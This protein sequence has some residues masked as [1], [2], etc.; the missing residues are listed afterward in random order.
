MNRKIIVHS[1]VL[2]FFL[3]GVSVVKGWLHLSYWPLWLGAAAGFFLPDVDHLVYV[4]FLGNQELTSQRI[5]YLIRNMNLVGALSLL[6]ETRAERTDLVLH[7]NLFLAITTVLFFWMFT[8]SASIFG[9]GLVSAI[10]VHLLLDRARNALYH[11]PHD[12]GI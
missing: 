10:T 1:L 2:I 4:F 11:G 7:T 5:V 9:V 3:F 12:D 6:V 8:S